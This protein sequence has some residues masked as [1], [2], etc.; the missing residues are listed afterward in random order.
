MKVYILLADGFEEVEAIAS[1]DVM[2]RA[3]LEVKMLSVIPSDYVRSTHNIYI[4]PDVC[5]GVGSKDEEAYYDADAIVL[6]GGMPG[7]LN[8]ASNTGV[9]RLVKRYAEEGKVVAAI[10]AAPSILG[11]IG[12]LEGKRATCFP[13]F[14]DRLTGAEHV[15]AGA[16]IDGKIIT[17]HSMGTAIDF[18]LSIVKVLLGGETAEKLE[19]S[20]CRL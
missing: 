13:G 10:C 4:K 14:E 3:G 9:I 18:G 8:L 15:K 5:F 11:E 6:P 12:L 20:L 19:K 17:G 16:V 2:K 1:A 7:T